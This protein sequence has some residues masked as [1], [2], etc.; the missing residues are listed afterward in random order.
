MKKSEIANAGV[1]ISEL[2]A[3]SNANVVSPV[4]GAESPMIM[5]ASI[6]K[7]LIVVNTN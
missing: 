6:D 3:W 7:I 5:M 4:S 2:K 1:K